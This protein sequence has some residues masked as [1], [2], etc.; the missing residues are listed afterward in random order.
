M[1]GRERRDLLVGDQRSGQFSGVVVSR[2]SGNL[3]ALV[4]PC[5]RP[6]VAGAAVDH[7]RGPA[8]RSSP[9]G[10]AVDRVVAGPGRASRR[11]GPGSYPR[12]AGRAPAGGAAAPGD[13]DGLTPRPD[14]GG[15]TP[16]PKAGGPTP[17]PDAGGPTPRP[18]SGRPTPRPHAGGPTPWHREADLPP[19]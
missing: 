8:H 11:G 16:P 13:A 14:A 10:S 9:G 5:R 4:R 18:D 15:P 2:G 3:G 12:P 6:I 17:R 19:A 1:D 7:R